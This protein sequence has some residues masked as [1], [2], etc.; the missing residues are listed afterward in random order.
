LETTLAYLS[1]GENV[2]M[3]TP[4]SSL[5]EWLLQKPEMITVG[6]LGTFSMTAVYEALVNTLSKTSSN[7]T[8]PALILPLEDKAD[9][10]DCSWTQEEETGDFYTRTRSQLDNFI[11]SP[12]QTTMTT[13][14]LSR[15][16]RR[17]VHATAQ[18]M[19]LGHA[20]LGPPR[21]RNRRMVIFKP[22][23]DNGLELED[24]SQTVPLLHATSSSLLT[25]GL[26]SIAEQERSRTISWADDFDSG[27]LI[28]STTS[29]RKRK[30]LEKL[31]NGYPCQ[32]PPC[33]KLFDRAS[34]RNKHEQ[35][36]QPAFTNRHTCALCHKGFRYPK[37]L[38]RHNAR[39]HENA[40]SRAIFDPTYASFG[41]MTVSST[42]TYESRIPSETSLT[43]NSQPTSKNNSPMLLGQGNGMA[44]IEEWS[45]DDGSEL[46]PG[47]CLDA[48]SGLPF[49][50]LADFDF[51]QHDLDEEGFLEMAKVRR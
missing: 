22:H 2:K 11:L 12:D 50:E 26:Q 29:Q 43:F 21:S 3:E 49:Q 10:S 14:E 31:N 18:V 16:E 39:V 8:T 45:L 40:A 35:A 13:D 41:S 20:S 38:R 7:S 17:F 37:D 4:N 6:N 42:L 30:R 48:E 24:H 32:F 36:H 1:S 51:D 28:S 33:T 9:D 46:M 34:E 15:H 25:T 19:H 47:L 27:S 5:N 44:A 23:R